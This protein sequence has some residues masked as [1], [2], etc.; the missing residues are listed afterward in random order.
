MTTT[1]TT[2]TTN[3]SR[4]G[5]IAQLYEGQA[6]WTNIDKYI[7]EGSKHKENIFFSNFDIPARSFSEG[8]GI[9]NNDFLKNQN[10][11]K[12]VEWFAILAKGNIVLPE[13]EIGGFYHVVSISDDGI[14]VIVDGQ[15][16]INKPGQQA[17]TI[18]CATKLIELNP[19][20]EKSFELT[21][22]QGPREQ[23]ALSTYIKKIDNP[24]AFVKG[25]YCGTTKAAS[26]LLAD[27]Y[28]IISP[29][30]FTLPTGF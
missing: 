2:T 3:K 12:L 18:D 14:R 30:W 11:D 28:S 13:K 8:F 6:Q 19:L 9:G 22:F 4:L 27:G 5:L 29:T 7:L 16:I 26:L 20:V 1:T 25:T 10:G 21:Y 15:T 17:P 23:I 24:A